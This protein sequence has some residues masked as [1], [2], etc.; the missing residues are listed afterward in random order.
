MIFRG[1]TIILNR[2]LGDVSQTMRL[3][4]FYPSTTI[5]PM[6][7]ILLGKWLQLKCFSVDLIG[8]L[9]LNMSNSGVGNAL[10]VVVSL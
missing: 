3:G 4:V 2:F 5:R 9:Y 7:G 8:L 10:D 6:Q 1:F